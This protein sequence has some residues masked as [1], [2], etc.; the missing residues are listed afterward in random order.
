M[1]MLDLRR[2]DARTNVLEN[3]FWLTSAMLTPAADD[4]EAVF[5]SFPAAYGDN[6]YLVQSICVETIIAFAGGTVAITIGTGTIPLESSGDGATVSVVDAN[7]YFEDLAD[8]GIGAVGLDFPDGSAFLTALA[9]GT[10]EALVITCADATVPVI[11]AA[12]TSNA[13]ITAGA[14]RIHALVSRIPM[15]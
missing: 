2:Q 6:T 13:T 7:F 8:T 5:F 11:Y 15:Q 1:G 12:L 10:H 14:A 3:P 4:L 9:A